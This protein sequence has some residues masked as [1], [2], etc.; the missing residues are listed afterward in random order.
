M[1]LNTRKNETKEN[2]ESLQFILHGLKANKKRT[3]LSEKL[4]TNHKTLYK[5][6]YDTWIHSTY[7]DMS[8]FWQRVTHTHIYK[9]TH[10]HKETKKSLS[11]SQSKKEKR[12][13]P[14]HPIFTV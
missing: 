5:Q 12:D 4:N 6:K 2:A 11:A 14:K 7:S 10:T 8:P 9:Q 13:K 3:T 1:H